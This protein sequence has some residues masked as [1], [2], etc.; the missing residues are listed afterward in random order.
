MMGIPPADTQQIF[1]WT[2]TILGV[3]DPEYGGSYERL[4]EVSLA[5]FAYAQ[6]LGEDR[7]RIRPTTSRRR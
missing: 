3:G 5:I 2:N 4:M 6:A 1:D 7:G